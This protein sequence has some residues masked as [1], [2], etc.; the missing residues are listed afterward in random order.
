MDSASQTK[1]DGCKQTLAAFSSLVSCDR[2][3]MMF[4][5]SEVRW[6]GEVSVE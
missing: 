5:V 4:G 1:E 2:S 6:V 3:P